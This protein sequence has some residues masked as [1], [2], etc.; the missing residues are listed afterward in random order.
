MGITDKGAELLLGQLKKI[1][2]SVG[3]PMIIMVATKDDFLST[4]NERLNELGRR[5]RDSMFAGAS[6]TLSR[7]LIQTE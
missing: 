6:L 1:V 2:D 7:A 5:E 3:E 4:H